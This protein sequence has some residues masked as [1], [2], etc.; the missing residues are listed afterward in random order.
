MFSDHCPLV[1]NQSYRRRYTQDVNGV[2]QGSGGQTKAMGEGSPTLVI[3]D[4]L[5]HV[6]YYLTYNC[7][8]MTPAIVNFGFPASVWNGMLV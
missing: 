6:K 2:K 3:C 7:Y 1:T 4:M 5:F 8:E